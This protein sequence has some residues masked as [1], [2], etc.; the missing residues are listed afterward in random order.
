MSGRGR[1][2]KFTE[3]TVN[4]LLAAIRAGM[5]FH[6]AAAHAGIGETT[7]HEWQRGKFPRGADKQ[8]K[9]EFPERLTRA[10]GYAALRLVALIQDAAPKDWRAAA[11][12]LER[13]YPEDFGR[14]EAV[15]LTGKGGEPLQVEA[16]AMQRVILKALEAHPEAKVAVADALAEEHGRAVGRR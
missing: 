13:R 11:W 14:R 8:L 2:H 1:P 7:F 6:L 16:S 5:P 9:A 10:R 15:E 12:M 3:E 4:T